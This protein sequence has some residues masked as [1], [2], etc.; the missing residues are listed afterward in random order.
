MFCPK[1]GHNSRVKRTIQMDA[2]AR[3]ERKCLNPKC[4]HRFYTRVV[5][6]DSVQVFVKQVT[7]EQAA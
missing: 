1:C 2:S 3:Q 7:D 6:E 4:E 5:Y